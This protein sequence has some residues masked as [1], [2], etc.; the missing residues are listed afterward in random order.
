[1]SLTIIAI[2]GVDYPSYATV[3]EADA[4]L[5]IDL[6]RA[7]AWGR[8]DE[9]GKRRFLAAATRRFDGLR[10]AGRKTSE[11]QATEWPRVGLAFPNGE[12]VGDDVL[13]ESVEQAAILLAG[14]LAIDPDVVSA[15]AASPGEVQSERV[16]PMAVT[17]FSRRRVRTSTDTPIAGASA[18]ALIRQWLEGAGVAAPVATGTDA[19][20]QF[21]T[22]DRY[23]RTE[24]VG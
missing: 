12:S 19:E 20:S 11:T 3:A 8:L 2:D 22:R 1:M 15:S 17:Y 24:G 7:E 23:G 18:F 21:L 10:W 5:A 6:N 16:G 14:D 9:T 4:Y 13:P